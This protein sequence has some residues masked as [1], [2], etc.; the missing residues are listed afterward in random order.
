MIERDERRDTRLEQ[1]IDQSL[2]EGEPPFVRSAS[3]LREDARPGD[4][5]AIGGCPEFTEEPDIIRP[6]VIVVAGDIA[7]VPLKGLSWRVA[8]GVP[9]RRPATILAYRTFYLV[10]SSRGTPE[11]TVRESGYAHRSLLSR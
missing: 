9:D 11:E 1:R 3:S 2:V 8:E 10:C 5:E 7:G 6:A 4:R